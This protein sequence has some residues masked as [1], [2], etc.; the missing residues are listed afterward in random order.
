MKCYAQ[1]FG[2]S[3]YAA[4]EAD[5]YELFDSLGEAK[6]EFE[7]RADPWETYYPCVDDVP[8]DDGGPIMLVWFGE[9]EGMYPCDC[10]PD[11][12]ITFGPRGGVVS[13]RV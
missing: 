13:N 3:S 12:E 9:P 4:P 7:R 8:A 5:D 10:P 2:G 11:R 1:W 6:R